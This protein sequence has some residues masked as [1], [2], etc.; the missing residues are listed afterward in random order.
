MEE[1]IFSL[2]EFD[3]LSKENQTGCAI[4]D[5]GNVL[6]FKE[7]YFHREDGPAIERIN[8]DKEWWKD[9]QCHRLNGPAV[10]KSNG[11]KYWYFDGIGCQ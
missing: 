11:E 4:S 10:E 5:N 1:K 7:G 9:G 6:W 2:K 3:K 8:G